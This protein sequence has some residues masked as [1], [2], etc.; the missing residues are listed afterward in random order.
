MRIAWANQTILDIWGKGNDVI[1]KL[2]TQILPELENQQIFDQLDTVF[3]SG[4]PFHAKNQR[5]DIEVD[6]M[7][8]TFYFNYSFTP[9]FD[10]AGAVYGV[11]NTAADVTDLNLAKQK[12]EESEANLRSIILQ[13][14]VAM[15]IFRGKD[16]VIE[17]ANKNMIEFWGKTEEG[18]LNK[19]IFEAVPEAKSQGYE[20]LMNQVLTTGVPFS[21]SEL[22]VT[23]PRNG[24]V[25]TVFINFAYEPIREAD[26]TISGIIAMAIDVTE[27]VMSRKKIEESERELQVRVA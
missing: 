4:E 20:E 25:K 2:Y 6:G 12:S 26:G 9:L 22:P 27:H 18:V 5:V 16:F 17:I 7:L 19:P 10:A 13:A 21:A 24:V 8:R 3:T 14:P 15:C 11:M 1:G 23:L